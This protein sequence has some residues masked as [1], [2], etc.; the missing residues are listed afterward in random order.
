MSITTVTRSHATMIKRTDIV[1]RH[2]IVFAQGT[3][4]G[5]SFIV[6]AQKAMLH[7]IEENYQI[8][9][10]IGVFGLAIRGKL[11]PRQ[12]CRS[13]ERATDYIL[14]QFDPPSTNPEYARRQFAQ[15]QRC[16]ELSGRATDADEPFIVGALGRNVPCD[17]LQ[18]R[19][20]PI[21]YW[22]KTSLLRL[23]HLLNDDMLDQYVVIHCL[24]GRGAYYR[25]EG[26]VQ[27][28]QVLS[29]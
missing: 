11:E 23:S 29:T 27:T 24:F 13:R 16:V 6:P 12:A 1:A 22:A 3:Q 21:R 25:T 7:Y 10:G 8:D 9:L 19:R 26:S 18:V 2:L 5:R 15:L 4:T 14:T 28:P 20:E 17:I